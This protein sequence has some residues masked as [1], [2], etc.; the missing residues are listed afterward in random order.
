MAV[1]AT[2]VGARFEREG[3]EF[4]A[5]AW[6]MAPR[7]LFD[8]RAA[9]DACMEREG[10]QR[11]LL[12]HGLQL[13]LDADPKAIDALLA[14]DHEE[15][16][17][18]DGLNRVSQP[19]ELILKA[20]HSTDPDPQLRTCW[21]NLEQGRV[22]IFAFLAVVSDRPEDIVERVIGRFGKDAAAGA[23]FHVGFDHTTPLGVAMISDALADTLA[24][25]AGDPRS[26]L[27]E[28]F[29]VLV[30]QRFKA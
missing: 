11:N 26:A 7:E 1:A 10:F 18:F 3:L 22:R 21:L 5:A 28:G 6:M 4:D 8:G 9:I 30:E 23:T 29:E 16:A 17:E 27:A 19:D 14:D 12:L 13:G 15:P 25:C 20:D 24:L 2:E